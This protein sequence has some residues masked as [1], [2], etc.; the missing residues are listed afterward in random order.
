MLGFGDR[1]GKLKVGYDADFV[2][3]N[4]DYEVL[5]TFSRGKEVFKKRLIL[6]I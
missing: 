4:S 3:I 5:S 1:K 2:V 6:R